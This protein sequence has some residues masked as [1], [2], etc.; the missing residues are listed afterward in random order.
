MTA[1][2]QRLGWGGQDR[3]NITELTGKQV[4]NLSTKLSTTQAALEITDRLTNYDPDNAAL[5]SSRA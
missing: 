3:L 2:N 4:Q 1:R 5:K